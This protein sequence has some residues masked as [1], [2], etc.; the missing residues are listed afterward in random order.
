[1]KHLMVLLLGVIFI[2]SSMGDV[3]L[4]DIDFSEPIHHVDNPVSIG[5]GSAPRKMLR[6]TLTGTPLA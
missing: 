5:E 2:Q 6:A 3:L 1:M 4:Y